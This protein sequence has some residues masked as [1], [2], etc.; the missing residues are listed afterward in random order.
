MTFTIPP[1]WCGVIATI[2]GEF[3][4]LVTYAVIKIIK[5]KRNSTLRRK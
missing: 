4:A 5:K 1:F 3:F 2:A